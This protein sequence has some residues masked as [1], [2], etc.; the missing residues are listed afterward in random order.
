VHKLFVEPGE[1]WLRVARRAALT[2]IKVLHTAVW[3]FF[4]GC[5]VSLP[6]AGWFRRFDIA[7]LLVSCVLVECA[8]LAL[9]RGQC[10]LTPIAARF[11]VDLSPSFDI[12]L[13]PWIAKWNKVLFG[14]LFVVN[15]AVVLGIWLAVRSGLI[16]R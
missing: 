15:G 13:P 16:S 6:L 4:V 9:N 12:Y 5:I 10:P 8:V 2:A 11:T 3:A 1:A 14:S 7:L